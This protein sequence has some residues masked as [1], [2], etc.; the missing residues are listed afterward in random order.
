MRGHNDPKIL[1]GLSGYAHKQAAI[2]ICMAEQCALHWLPHLKAR[3]ITLSWAS[4]YEHLLINVQVPTDD[5][6]EQRSDDAEADLDHDL[7]EDGG[8]GLD[9]EEEHEVNEE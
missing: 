9:A 4:V 5:T 3:G 1:S 8:N 6:D 7:D 2:C